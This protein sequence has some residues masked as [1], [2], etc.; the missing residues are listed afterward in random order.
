MHQSTAA[1]P[2]SKLGLG[3]R[4]FN[5]GLTDV[6]SSNR[7]HHCIQPHDIARFVIVNFHWKFILTLYAEVY[8]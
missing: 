3:L 8:L 5:I 7:I 1:I 2:I 4:S 6:Y